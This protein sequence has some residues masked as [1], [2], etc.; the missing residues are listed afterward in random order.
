MTLLQVQR[1]QAAS[2]S[3]DVYSFGVTVLKV[4]ASD[5][6]PAQDAVSGVVIITAS[7]KSED[8]VLANFLEAALAEGP[9]KR[10]EASEL[11]GV[12]SRKSNI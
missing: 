7:I 8:P 1:G 5:L 6:P 2:T 3:S 10:P 11:L 4:F 12:L 9:Q